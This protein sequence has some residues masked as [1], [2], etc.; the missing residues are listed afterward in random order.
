MSRTSLGLSAASQQ[1]VAGGTCAG[2][3]GHRWEQPTA[4]PVATRGAAL[5][6]PTSRPPLTCRLRHRPASRGRRRR[7]KLCGR[8]RKC[9]APWTPSVRPS[10]WQPNRWKGPGLPSGTCGHSGLDAFWWQLSPAARAR[11]RPAP[12]GPKERRRHL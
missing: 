5:T 11:Q 8:E 6:P 3:E 1:P 2:W 4:R 7:L 10:A 9:S 12:P